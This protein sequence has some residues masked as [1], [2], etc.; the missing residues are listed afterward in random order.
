MLYLNFV[1][2]PI[3]HLIVGGISMFR[4][5]DIH[6]RRIVYNTFDLIFV[7]SG[8][9]YMED[10]EQKFTLSEGQ[11]LIIFPDSMHR[12]FKYCDEDTTF[13]WVH[14]YTEGKYFYSSTPSYSEP[15]KM[16]KNK[17]YKKDNFNI[18]ITKCGSINDE[19]RKKFEEYLDSISQVKIDRYYHAKSFYSSAIS[20]IEYQIVFLKILTMICELKE[21]NKQ[22]D[23]VTDIYDYISINYKKPFNLKEISRQF[24][25]H[26]AHII[27]CVKQRYGFT[28]VQLLLNIRIEKAKAL[29]SDTDQPVN[30]IAESVG[31]T[32]TSYFSKQF[33][34]IIGMTPLE[35]RRNVN[36][37]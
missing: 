5:G 29:L 10:N 20:Q 18:S 6:E 1:C 34:K 7:R 22:K 12:G 37:A 8:K 23:F 17:Y 4:R 26:P 9:L 21:E 14:F 36:K 2:P 25:F 16:N 15:P 30:H 13:S 31:F 3:P 35:Y 11:F 28:P 27:R 33:K 32:D 19:D 24:S